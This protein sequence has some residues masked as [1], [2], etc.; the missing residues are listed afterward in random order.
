[1]E[2]Q[3]TPAAPV[4]L[5]PPTISPPF[6]LSAIARAPLLNP[7][8]LLHHP[9]LTRLLN[10]SAHKALGSHLSRI[11]FQRW[12]FSKMCTS[13]LSPF[14]LVFSSVFLNYSDQWCI[15]K[16][17]S[18]LCSVFVRAGGHLNKYIIAPGFS[19]NP[20]DFQVSGGG[21]ISLCVWDLWLLV[22]LV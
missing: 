15:N 22:A 12:E 2:H 19:Y 20:T 5:F 6:I 1:M 17:M 8:L 3:R 16:S 14:L 18:W 4:I 13:G 7:Q 21:R 10:P 9:S 11:R